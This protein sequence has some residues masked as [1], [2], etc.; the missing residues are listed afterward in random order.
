[1]YT[2]KKLSAHE[3]AILNEYTERIIVKGVN[4]PAKL[5]DEVSLHMHLEVSK[6]PAEKRQMLSLIH[7]RESIFKDKKILITDDDMRNVFL[8]T[9]LLEQKGMKVIVAKNGRDALNSL[10]DNHGIDLIIMDIMMPEMDGYTAIREIRKQKSYANI[11]IIALTAKAMKGDRA[12]C[13]EAGASDYISKP[14]EKERLFSVL[15][16]WLY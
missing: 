15:R 7:D 2:G 11:P 8:V 9:N 1:M 16:A 5:L 12:K 3:R 14:F 6:L 10:R 4:S 13:L